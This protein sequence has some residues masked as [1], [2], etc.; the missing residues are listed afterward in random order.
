MATAISEPLDF[1]DLNIKIITVHEIMT[2]YIDK[3]ENSV[4]FEDE[5]QREIYEVIP[6]IVTSEE[7]NVT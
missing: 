6:E 7:K 5:F 3:A 1:K 2:R 4:I